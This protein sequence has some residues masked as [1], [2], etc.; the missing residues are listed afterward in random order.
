MLQ[1]FIFFLCWIA[2]MGLLFLFLKNKNNNLHFQDV[3]FS[4]LLSTAVGIVFSFAAW[5]ANVLHWVSCVAFTGLAAY[6]TYKFLE[7]KNVVA[8]I[9]ATPMAAFSSQKTIR[10]GSMAAAD[11]K[12]NKNFVIGAG[13]IYLLVLLSFT[14]FNTDMHDYFKTAGAFANITGIILVLGS[15]FLVFNSQ[16][17]VLPAKSGFVYWVAVVVLLIIGLWLSIGFQG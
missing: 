9:T 11:A 14:V 17:Q 1:L 13:V 4:Y 10:P 15:Y 6:I 2:G 5:K 16:N 12:A 7:K 3:L 8:A